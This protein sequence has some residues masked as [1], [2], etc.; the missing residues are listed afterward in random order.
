MLSPLSIARALG[1]DAVGRNQILAPG[2]GHS[3]RDRSLSIRIN[4]GAPDGFV[5]F[6]HAGD[7]PIAC[8]RYA[9]ERL[10]LEMSHRRDLALPPRSRLV[11]GAS[12]DTD[13]SE[14]AIGIWK[15]AVE[16]GKTL[17]ET[18]LANRGLELPEAGAAVIR[19][20]PSCP[21]KGARHPAMIALYRDIITDQPKAIHRT[22]FSSEGRKMDRAMLGP[23]AGCVIKLDPDQ[24]ITHGLVIGEGIETVQ[25]ARQLGFRPAWAASTSG[26]IASF[27]V[28]AGIEGLSILIDRDPAGERAAKQCASSWSAA[29]REVILVRTAHVGL[30]DLNDAILGGRQ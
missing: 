1:G 11:D 19:F 26:A 4:P 8:K 27:P 20:H 13:R 21:F 7:D 9:M 12:D 18:Y 23:V 6:S 30:N 17:V 5:V 24:S 10:G 2:P 16:P 15:E 3:A 25:A 29:G 14:L 28:L 22:V